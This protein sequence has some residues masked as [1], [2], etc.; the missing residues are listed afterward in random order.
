LK[1]RADEHVSPEIVR[2]V[3]KMA[4]GK[5]FEFSHVYEADQ[6]GH[7]DEHWVTAFAKDGGNAI[8]TADS[9]FHK[10]AAQIMAVFNT[11]MRVS[12]MV[13][14][15]VALIATLCAVTLAA[16][17][18]QPYVDTT[19]TPGF[20]MGLLHGFIAGFALIGHIFNHE[21]RVYA[22]PNSGG[23]YDFGF[24]FGVSLWSGSAGAA[25]SR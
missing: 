13:K 6:A 2:A 16:C 20:F 22:Y 17:A 21:I 10:R 15:R 11:G 24:L 25:G 23:W 19:D 14:R 3:N 18:S 4:L 12:K 8:V 9:D 5:G 7:Q 1:I